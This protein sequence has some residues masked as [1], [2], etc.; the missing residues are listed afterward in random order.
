MP[1]NILKNLAL[2]GF[3]GS[4]KTTVGKELARRVGWTFLD[5]DRLIWEKEKDTIP[6]IFE[7]HG[8]IYFRRCEH[9]VLAEV[10]A[11]EKIVLATGGGLPIGE[12]CWEIL[13]RDFYTVYLKAD[14]DGL[15][16]RIAGDQFRPLLQKY[17]T[18]DRLKE[19]YLSRLGWYERAHVIIDTTNKKIDVII[20]EIVERARIIDSNQR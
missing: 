10:A 7:K 16:D 9:A 13:R 19:L 11:L 3:M 5:S 2:I 20:G 17:P 18:R 1:D 12:Q 6:E 15:F 4:G 8:E 14:F